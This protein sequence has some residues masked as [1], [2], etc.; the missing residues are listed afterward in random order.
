MNMIFSVLLL[1]QMSEALHGTILED[2]DGA[3]TLAH[4]LADLFDP[5]ALAKA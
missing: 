1:K 2:L 4:N 3:L 5:Q